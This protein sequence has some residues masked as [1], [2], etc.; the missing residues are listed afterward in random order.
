MVWLASIGSGWSPYARCP[1]PVTDE[2]LARHRA[3]GVENRR[4]ADP[5]ASELPL[6]HRLALRCE[7]CHGLGSY[8]NDR[9]QGDV[10]MKE[11]ELRFAGSVP[12]SLRASHG[13]A[14]IPALCDELARRARD[15]RPKTILETASGTGVVT[16]ALHAAMPDADI[17]ATDLNQPMLD[18][19]QERLRSATS[20]SGRP[21][22]WHL[23]FTDGSFDL[24][25]CQF[26]VMFFPDK[27]R[28]HAEALRVLRD[29][30]SYLLAIWDRI[31]RNALTEVAQQVLIDTFPDDPPLFMREGP[32]GYADARQDRS[33]PASSWF[34]NGRNRNRRA[35]K[36]QRVRA[37]CRRRRYATEPRWVSS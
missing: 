18:I 26:G 28:G 2:R 25:V 35:E 20:G 13:A 34:R 11:Q 10:P 6:D 15:R 37:Q 1:Y 8:Q 12:A 23:P 31:E 19:A 9:E 14:D 29:G 33:R 24:V 3:E 27:V 4:L 5:A 36:P 21:T 17:V 32:F 16:R 7:V 22:R 30:G